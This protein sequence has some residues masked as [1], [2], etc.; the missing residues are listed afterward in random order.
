MDQY[1]EDG[2]DKRLGA[3]TPVDAADGDELDVQVDVEERRRGDRYGG[4]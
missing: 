4:F 1:E 3:E 2:P